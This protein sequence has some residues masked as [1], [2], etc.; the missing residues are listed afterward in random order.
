MLSGERIL[1]TGVTGKSVLPIARF[2]AADNEVWGMARFADPAQRAEIEAAGI[3]PIAA[4]FGTADFSHVPDDFTYLLH[5]GWM[6]ANIAQLPAAMQVNVQ[7][8]GLLL[9]HCR[10]AKAAL[11]VS[12][13]GIYSP[14]PDPMHR[15]A[16]GD[17]IG[18]AFTAAA[19]TSPATK[20]GL[21]FVARFCAEAFN[22]PIT[23][24]R[25]NSVMGVRGSYFWRHTEAILDGEEIVTPHDPYMHS[26][27]HNDD[28]KLHIAPLLEAA[29][30][31][32]LV[33]NWGGDEDISCQDACRFLGGLAGKEPT[34][35]LRPVEGSPSSSMTDA[36]LRRS[37]T[38]P[39][40]VGL[41]GGLRRLY[42]DVARFRAALAG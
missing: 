4:D 26:P 41:E 23:I 17:P 29:S 31:K 7:G 6:R 16:E 34:F 42:D 8:P 35:A 19:Q 37:I 28:M 5:F 21:E 36:T 39:C 32:A 20:M 24:A 9:Q 30:V 15:Y 11:V 14:H 33:T 12:S 27:I 3:V 25:L 13:Q 18:R 10:K 1:V 22:L 40:T 2:L 38:G